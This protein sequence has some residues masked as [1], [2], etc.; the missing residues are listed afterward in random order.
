MI[1]KELEY[2]IFY[3]LRRFDLTV[4]D[5]T[6]AYDSLMYWTDLIEKNYG[7]IAEWMDQNS[8]VAQVLKLRDR[9]IEEMLLNDNLPQ[10]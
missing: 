6:N 7:P 2:E 1:S 9:A 5:A 10:R 3:T 8:A 4:K